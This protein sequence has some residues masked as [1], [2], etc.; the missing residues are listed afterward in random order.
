MQFRLNGE[1]LYAL[2]FQLGGI[3]SGLDCDSYIPA[4][5]GLSDREKIKLS[6][7]KTLPVRPAD[8]VSTWHR[9]RASLER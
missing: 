2:C 6:H 7:G 8:E 9:P 3:I 4:A 1:Y 5:R